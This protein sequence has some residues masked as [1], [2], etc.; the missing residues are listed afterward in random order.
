ML[1]KIEFEY[2]EPV[3]LT[4]RHAQGFEVKARYYERWPGD[5]IQYVFFAFEGV[6]YLSDTA[7]SLLNARL[8]ARGIAAGETVFIT[9]IKAPNPNSTRAVIEYI[10]QR[11][12]DLARNVQQRG[13]PT[14]ESSCWDQSGSCAY[15]DRISRT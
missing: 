12:D 7:G 6:F 3:A 9:K 14:S 4:L 5:T 11:C 13:F 2:D 8:R 10:P 15:W 1:P